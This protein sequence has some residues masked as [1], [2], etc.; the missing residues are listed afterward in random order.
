MLRQGRTFCAAGSPP[1]SA[2][3]RWP[4]VTSRAPAGGPGRPGIAD[5]AGPPATGAC[6]GSSAG[7]WYVTWPPTACA[8]R[9]IYHG[10]RDRVPRRMTCEPGAQ[11]GAAAWEPNMRLWPGQIRRSASG[12]VRPGLGR[13]PGMRGSGR[14]RAGPR[15]RAG[16][17]TRARPSRLLGVLLAGPPVGV[18]RG[19][20]RAG[21][22]GR[23][24]STRAAARACKKAGDSAPCTSRRRRGAP[25]RCRCSV[26]ARTAAVLASSCAPARGR[27]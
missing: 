12:W 27:T 10:A 21:P 26:V 6:G 23:A 15:E 16:R 11:G 13:P 14:R 9:P 18:R 8:P 20:P 7:A 5:P 4:I 1:G 22:Q 19:E 25:P 24:G 2:P 17:A 3:A